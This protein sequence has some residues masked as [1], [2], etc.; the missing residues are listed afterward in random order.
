M[1]S[2]RQSV[3][4][5]LLIS[6]SGVADSCDDFNKLSGP[7][8]VTY[9]Q[10]R[11]V[12]SVLTRWSMVH[13]GGGDYDWSGIAI[14]SGGGAR[15]S[16][17]LKFRYVEDSLGSWVLGFFR[18]AHADVQALK[19]TAKFL[20]PDISETKGFR[21]LKPTFTRN[22]EF[23][24]KPE[25]KK[26]HALG[27]LS[28]ARMVL[29]P[30]L[31]VLGK[32]DVVV[33]EIANPWTGLLNPEKSPITP[34]FLRFS[35]ANP[36]ADTV[37]I[38]TPKGRKS[39]ALEFI[40][41]VGMKFIIHRRRSVDLVAMDSLAGQGKN[42]NFFAY[43]FSPDFSARA[44]E[45]YNTAAGRAKEEILKRYKMNPTNHH[46]MGLVG[47]RFAEVIPLITKLKGP[48]DPH[49]NVGPHPFI[50]SIAELAA[51]DVG[52]DGVPVEDQRRPWRLVFKP[53][54]KTHNTDDRAKLVDSTPYTPGKHH[55]DFR[56]KLAHFVPGDTVFEVIGE[57]K[58]GQRYALGEIVLET[59]VAMSDFADQLVFVQHQLE[60][61]R[62][63]GQTIVDPR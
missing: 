2:V 40:P 12:D 37:S 59:P 60:M 14:A 57:T 1:N 54:V 25:V 51:V 10:Q 39:L 11:Q 13:G 35:I 43:E 62:I 9:I 53:K 61:G 21:S 6:I 45:A 16:E 20:S 50:M 31:R 23:L 58:A 18:R 42:Q 27:A 63:S 17:H 22:C 28:W 44:P 46:V 55:T 7:E 32:E 15:G 26:V 30:K 48:I 3:L 47:K 36:I 24:E 52:G 41:G 5:L 49:S 29:Y 8:K 34:L 56:Y 19:A 38:P 33:G 4:F